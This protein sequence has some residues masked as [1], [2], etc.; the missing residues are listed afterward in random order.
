MGWGT[1]H[2]DRGR[3]FL[4]SWGEIG[5][6]EKDMSLRLGHIY[7]QLSAIIQE[8]AP[9]VMVLETVF[10]NINPQSALTLGY[11]RGVALAVAGIQGVSVAEY[12]PNTIKKN[13]TGYGHAPK[14]HMVAMIARLF[15]VT[16]PPDAADAISAGLCH[17]RH[18][19]FT[20]AL[21]QPQK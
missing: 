5:S 9:S 2:L 16:V 18:M 12:A 14:E 15:S 4:G 10:V 6:K 17:A 1:I 8:H 13:L 7:T 21:S 20:R 19:M 3:E 11:A